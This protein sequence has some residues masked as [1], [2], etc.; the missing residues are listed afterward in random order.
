M[1]ELPEVETFVR[2]LHSAVGSTIRDVRVLDARLGLDGEQI[3][4]AVITTIERQGKYIVFRLRSRGDLV[5]HLRM[6]GRLRVTRSEKERA[7]TRL[8]LDLEDGQSVYFVNPRRLGT[9]EYFPE[10]FRVSLGSDPL[11]PSFTAEALTELTS[12]SRSPIK[13]FLLNQQKIAGI[14]N[15]Y[16]AE[17]L[18]MS[19]IA[20][21]RHAQSLSQ[22]EVE[23]LHAAIVTV[24]T[25]AV[26]CQGT[27]IGHSVSDYHPQDEC[28]G[29]FQN[30]LCVYGREDEP[31]ERCGES[32]V[33]LKQ[34]GRSTYFCNQCQ[35]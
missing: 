22:S 20:P 25:D 15:I 4:G 14:G 28:E 13:T 30:H 26:A 12:R 2:N 23:R 17:A 10:G 16:A 1:P 27:T 33:R 3:V 34:A 11:E 5:F 9:A 6:S 31:C 24:L 8:V 29:E 7:Y 19:G 35:V 32:I 18:W 21:T